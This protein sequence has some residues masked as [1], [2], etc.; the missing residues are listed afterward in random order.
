MA[1]VRAF[2]SHYVRSA[3]PF[4][5]GLAFG[6]LRGRLDVALPIEILMGL[7]LVLVGPIVIQAVVMLVSEALHGQPP[8]AHGSTLPD[9]PRFHLRTSPPPG[10]VRDSP[11]LHPTFRA[12]RRP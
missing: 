5:S 9:A 2:W 3:L 12:R 7:L 10:V 11:L 4:G 1:S 8:D 6:L